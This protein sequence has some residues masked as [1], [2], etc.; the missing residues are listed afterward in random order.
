MKQLQQIY[1]SLAQKQV[2]VIPFS[3]L[4]L[5]VVLLTG[6][7]HSKIKSGPAIKKVLNLCDPDQNLLPQTTTQTF[8]PL[9]AVLYTANSLESLV[10]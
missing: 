6:N 9:F 1:T 10:K 8:I 4:F 7:Q 3:P 2:W 5:H